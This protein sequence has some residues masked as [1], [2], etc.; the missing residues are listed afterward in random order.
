MDSYVF[1]ARNM[2][3]PTFRRPPIYSLLMIVCRLSNHAQ[4]SIE[5]MTKPLTNIFRKNSE[6]NVALFLQHQILAAIAT[7]GLGKE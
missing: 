4:N 6:H 2:F 5:D 3:V 7:I 1:T